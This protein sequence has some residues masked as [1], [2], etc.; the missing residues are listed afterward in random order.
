MAV[1]LNVFHLWSSTKV[2]Q[3]PFRGGQTVD[4]CIA[5]ILISLHSPVLLLPPRQFRPVESEHNREHSSSPRPFR[6][7]IPGGSFN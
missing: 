2:K 4:R 6:T 7:N 5:V 1:V 3:H